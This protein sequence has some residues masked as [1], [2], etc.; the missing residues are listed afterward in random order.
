MKGVSIYDALIDRSVK[1]ML[2]SRTQAAL[3]SFCELISDLIALGE[4]SKPSEI[5]KAVLEKTRYIQELVAGEK[6]SV[7]AESKAQNLQELISVTRNFEKGQESGSLSDFLQE[8]ALL[9]DIDTLKDD[10]SGI[11]LMT[12]HS[13]KGL[14]FPVVFLVGM[15]EGVFP[16]ARSIVETGEIEEERRL[17]YV[18]ITRAMDRLFLVSAD[19]RML[20]GSTSA[21]P[22]SRFIEELPKEFVEEVGSG[23]GAAVSAVTASGRG[24]SISSSS[25]SSRAQSDATR[26]TDAQRCEWSAGA[27][28]RHAQ[29]GIG[30]IVSVSESGSDR[31][32][33]VAF[34]DKGV[35]RLMESY[36]SLE[37]VR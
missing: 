34:P 15:D 24:S 20:F 8:V 12:M 18:G 5:V 27:K 9:S 7:E 37:P 16:F 21:N 35:K 26:A 10:N 23:S 1:A 4:G 22:P 28:V 32:L 29:F 11:T 14:E 30:T 6:D 36:A 33:T 17:C 31:I 2:G 19:S 25:S 3:E 13:T